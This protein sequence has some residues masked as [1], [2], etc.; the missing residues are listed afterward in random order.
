MQRKTN[1]LIFFPAAFL[2]RFIYREKGFFDSSL[3]NTEAI[4]KNK[5]FVNTPRGSESMRFYLELSVVIFTLAVRG[6][7]LPTYRLQRPRP[8]T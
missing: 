6:S 3:P 5:A 4:E 8:T 1:T 7:Y 2:K